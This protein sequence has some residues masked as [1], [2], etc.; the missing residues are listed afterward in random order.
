MIPSPHLFDGIGMRHRGDRV[1]IGLRYRGQAAEAGE[2]RLFLSNAQ[3]NVLALAMFMSL[4]ARQ[5]WSRLK[6]LLLDDPI[7]H[8]DDLDAVAF[9]DTLRAVALGRFGGRRQI[10]V[11]TCDRTIYRLMIQKFKLIAGSGASFTAVSLVDG[12]TEGPGVRYDFGRPD[13]TRMHAHGLG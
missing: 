11:S 6:T 7:Q 2:P 10:V 8:L 1:E 13:V 4:G 5:Q 12:G 3:L 9:L